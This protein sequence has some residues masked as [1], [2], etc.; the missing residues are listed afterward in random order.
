MRFVIPSKGR[1]KDATLELL[2]RAGIRPS[3]LDS[4]AL[5]VPSNKPNLDLVFARPED[6]PWIV[7]S[8][9][10]EVGITGHDYVLESGRDVAEILDLNYGRS[11]LVLAVPRDSGIKRPEE[12]PKGF[13]IA[14]KFINIATDYFEKKGLDVKIVKVSGSAEVMPGIGAADGIIDVMSTGTTLKLHGLTP[15]D[16]ILSSSARLI[17]RK[18]LLDDPRVETIK[19]MLESVLRASKKKLVMMNV[20]DE[21]LDDVLKV[22]PA[23]SGPTISKV[24]SEKPMWEVIAAVDEDEIADI[25]VKLKNAGAKDI[26]VLNVERLIP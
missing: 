21:A 23:M 22:L 13:R 10:A 25:I 7:E 4:R 6:I 1:L 2:E 16:V 12:L 9:A 11:K 18:D 14:T 3:Y 17:V 26:L 20:P 5:I 15:I 24:K 8:G 19:L